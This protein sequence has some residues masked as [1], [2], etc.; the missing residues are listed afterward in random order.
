MNR[1]WVPRADRLAAEALAA[2]DATGWFDR[3]YDAGRRGEVA[4]PWDRDDAHP[5]LVAWASERAPA[6]RGRRAVVV[7]CGLGADAEFVA[8]LGFDVVAFDVSPTAV[9]TVRERRPGSAVEYTVADLLDLPAA[10]RGAFDLV[11]EVHTV[12]ALPLDVRARA[13]AAVRSLLAPGGTLLVVAAA[14]DE[15]PPP[16]GPPWPLTPA[17]VTAFGSGLETADLQRYADRDEPA[18]SRW[19]AEFRRP[20]EG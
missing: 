20:P 12:Q 16:G 1:D 9:A 8:G 7:G 17:E 6:G 2:G 3:L 4:M 19:R 18:G 5:L 15:G 10:W 13:T 11:V 14:R